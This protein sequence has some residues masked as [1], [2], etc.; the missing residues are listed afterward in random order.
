MDF[1]T[2]IPAKSIFRSKVFWGAVI[3][4][5]VAV[6]WAFW[7]VEVDADTQLV[8]LNGAVT[9]L[10][11]LGILVGS[12]LSV[13]GR[14]KAAGPAKFTLAGAIASAAAIAQAVAVAQEEVKKK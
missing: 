10:S 3:N 7:G 4:I 8:V 9:G 1:I 14:V 13:Y 5:A 12:S 6:L 2:G 11:G